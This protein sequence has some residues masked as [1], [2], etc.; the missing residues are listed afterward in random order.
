MRFLILLVLVLMLTLDR[1][2]KQIALQQSLLSSGEIFRFS[3]FSFTPFFNNRLAFSV[4]LHFTAI[5]ILSFGVIC[6]L[7][8]HCAR[9]Q[10][11]FQRIALCFVIVGALSNVFDRAVYGAVVDY[12]SII[13]HGFFNIADIMIGGG[14]I[15]YIITGFVAK[16]N[17]RR[18]LLTN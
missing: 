7:G 15:A 1:L 10:N 18:A 6:A 12:F 3:I 2:F 9:L 14:S 17:K 11:N 5:I 16:K 4:P 8:V 13:P